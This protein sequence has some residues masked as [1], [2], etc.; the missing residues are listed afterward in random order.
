PALWTV[1]EARR[2]TPRELAEACGITP[3][4]YGLIEAGRATPGLAVAQLIA[5][6]LAVDWEIID[7]LRRPPGFYGRGA[8]GKLALVPTRPRLPSLAAAAEAEPS[9]IRRGPAAR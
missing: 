3:A 7:E 9:P 8:E 4:S 6:A 2:L 5:A 1:R